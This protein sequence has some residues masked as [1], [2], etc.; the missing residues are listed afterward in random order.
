[1]GRHRAEE[2][3]R[4]R[5]SQNLHRRPEVC[6]E[7]FVCGHPT[8]VEYV[9]MRGCVVRAVVRLPSPVPLIKDGVDG[10]R[11]H[12]LPPHVHPHAVHDFRREEYHPCVPTT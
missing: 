6:G 11:P 3:T 10:V 2:R 4:R 7:E 12:I 5:H 8:S 1:M 9:G